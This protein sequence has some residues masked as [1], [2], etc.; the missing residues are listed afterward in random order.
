MYENLCLRLSASALTLLVVGACGDSDVNSTADAGPTSDANDVAAEIDGDAGS[1]RCPPEGAEPAEGVLADIN[2]WTVSVDGA[3]G[4]W[5]ITAA[6]GDRPVLEGPGSCARGDEG[7]YSP[8]RLASGDARVTSAFGN[9]RIDLESEQ[10]SLEWLTT[11]NIAPTVTHEDDA[12]LIHWPLPLDRPADAAA[13]LRFLAEGS[14][15]I[16]VELTTN[17]D[18]LD[19]GEIVTACRPDE[20]FFGLGSQSVGMNLRGRTFPL[21]TQ[22]QGNGKPEDGGVFPL[23]NFPEAAYAPMGIWHS[24]AGY[25]AIMGHDSYAEIDLCEQRSDR[26]RLRSHKKLPRF[27]LVTGETPKERLT[28]I[29]E[30]TGRVAPEPP[31]WVFGPWFDAVGG[32]WRVE[33]VANTLRDN[34]IPASAIWTEDWIGGSSTASGYRLSYAWEW[35]DVLYPGLATTIDGL[36]E[37]GFAF[38]G[39]FNPFVPTTVRMFAEGE[40]NGYLI[41]DAE[42]ETYLFQDPAFR[43]ATLVD[44]TN[45]EAV[46]WM[47]D[48]MTAAANDLGLDGWMADFAEW[49]PVDAR[50]HSGQTGWEFHNQYPL[51]WQKANKDA[52]AEAHADQSPANDWTFFARSGWASTNGG[53]AGIAAAMWGGDQNTNWKYDDG[54]PTIVPIGA[55]LGLSGVSLFGS[56][57]AGYNSLGTSNTD[58]ELFFRWSATGAFHPLMRTHHGGDECDNWHFDRDAETLAHYRRYA[59]IH[60]LLYPY[61]DRLLTQATDEGLPII[62]HPF[63]VEPNRPALWTGDQYQFFVGDDIVVAPVLADDTTQ[64]RVILPEQAWWPLFGDSPALGT[65][66]QGNAVTVEA[67][68]AVTEVPVFVRPGTILP[69]LTEAVDSFYGSTEAGVSDLADVDNSRRLALY[70]DHV[71]HVALALHDGVSANGAGWTSTATL[72]W[73]SASLDA[74]ML[75]RCDTVGADQSC[76]DPAAKVVRL[77]DATES[78]LQVGNAQLAISADVPTDF[79][80]GVAADAWGEWTEPTPYSGLNAQAPSW[81]AGHVE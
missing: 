54:F 48:Y 73:T 33:E 15:N 76:V 71:G 5:S 51:A 42:G 40:E 59:S 22:E 24:S 13:E 26:V 4:A 27:V 25:S 75:S 78:T 43:S 80:I 9:F 57:I 77:V 8:V 37:R 32:P 6:G 44:L 41:K 12:V 55:H 56:D 61:F 35:D 50:L 53:S 7:G 65:P 19:T 1:P 11:A 36:H 74:A 52:L 21:W 45:P 81:C 67:N 47:Q 3:T 14:Q 46:D 31:A 29:T 62:R 63:L 23:N 20:A 68:A 17:V 79:I 10:A 34:D 66:A 2:G 64:R 38:L 18:A 60:A 30:Y 28:A 58:K 69:L 49:L 72:D 70:P 16:A 39:Y